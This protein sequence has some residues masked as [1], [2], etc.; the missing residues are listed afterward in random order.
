M[1]RNCSHKIGISQVLCYVPDAAHASDAYARGLLQWHVVPC[2]SV[3]QVVSSTMQAQ[4][5][6]H[7]VPCMMNSLHSALQH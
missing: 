1:G 7:G 5:A 4:H 6:T 2:N 3:V